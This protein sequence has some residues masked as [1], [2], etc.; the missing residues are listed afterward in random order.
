MG[1]IWSF[2]PNTGSD[3]DVHLITSH[4]MRLG[5]SSCDDVVTEKRIY[6]PLQEQLKKLWELEAIGL[7]T[8][9]ETV[10]EKFLDIIHL[11]NGRY[12]ASPPWNEQHALLPH[13]YAQAVSRLVSVLKRLR[14]NPGL[15]EEYNASSKSNPREG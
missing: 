2:A 4:T 15:F 5:A 12:E 7:S 3:T 13:N 1:F 8:Q 10:H 14:K 6:D 11:N 9:E